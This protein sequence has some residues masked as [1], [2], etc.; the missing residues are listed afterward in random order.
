MLLSII[1]IIVTF[2][3]HARLKFSV[4]A[5]I[6]SVVGLWAVAIY[7]VNHNNTLMF[8]IW[9]FF[10]ALTIT[11]NHK[12]LFK[13]GKLSHDQLEEQTQLTNAINKAIDDRNA[14]INQYR[15]NGE[16]E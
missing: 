7:T 10:V 3:L 1:I 5:L 11:D 12:K 16:S 4:T 15:T 9:C 14:I 6:A 2:L 13:Q 8:F